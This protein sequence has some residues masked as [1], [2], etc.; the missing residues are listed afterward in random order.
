MKE[1]IMSIR[2][3]I[4]KYWNLCYFS[5]EDRKRFK[6]FYT[7]DYNE[8]VLVIHELELENLRKHYERFK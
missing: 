1:F 2:E 8:D 5:E 4:V 6:T 3:E 7:N